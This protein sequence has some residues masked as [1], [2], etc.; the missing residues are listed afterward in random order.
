MTKNTSGTKV[1]RNCHREL[2][3]EDFHVNKQGKDGRRNVCKHCYIEQNIRKRSGDPDHEVNHRTELH[4]VTQTCT[5]CGR[6][7]PEEEFLD[8]IGRRI[9]SGRCKECREKHSEYHRKYRK[10]HRDKVRENSRRSIARARAG[11]P[12]LKP[13]PPK[14]SVFARPVVK[15]ERLCEKC[16]N[17]PCFRGI[18]NLESDFAREGCNGWKN[19]EEIENENNPC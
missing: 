13:G 11:L 6:E 17:W 14:G 12:K 5:E 10:E 15:G 9:G 3:L 7:L 18:E 19:R 8:S 16:V 1:C 4:P 2:P